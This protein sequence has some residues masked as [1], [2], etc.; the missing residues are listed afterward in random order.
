MLG[1]WEPGA[2]DW[3]KI[4]TSLPNFL[5]FQLHYFCHSHESGNPEVLLLLLMQ[6]VFVIHSGFLPP[7]RDGN[8]KVSSGNDKERRGNGSI[9]TGDDSVIFHIDS[10]IILIIILVLRRDGGIGRRARLRA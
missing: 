8:D 9:K 4:K 2:G 1:G 5:S 6:I 10:A 7:W 3:R